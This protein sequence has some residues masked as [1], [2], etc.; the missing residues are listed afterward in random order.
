MRHSR[1]QMLGDVRGDLEDRHHEPVVVDL[2]D[3]LLDEAGRL[4]RVPCERC[5]RTQQSDLEILSHGATNCWELVEQRGSA[6]RVAGRQR[7]HHAD[8]SSS[9]FRES[10][11]ETHR[12]LTVAER[13]PQTCLEFVGAS[14]QRR[15]FAVQDRSSTT[16]RH[17][18]RVE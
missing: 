18:R 5:R 7:D 6:V 13:E 14:E 4:R 2:G 11:G 17:Q 8:D 15:P 3:R 16:D 1:D 12:R 10:H 9:R